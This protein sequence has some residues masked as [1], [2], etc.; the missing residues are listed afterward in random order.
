MKVS[1]IL[2]GYLIVAVLLLG[3]LF[4]NI[5]FAVAFSITYVTLFL[6]QKY[7]TYHE[8]PLESGLFYFLSV[9]FPA[10]IL[11]TLKKDP[12]TIII[13]IIPLFSFFVAAVSHVFKNKSIKLSSLFF[14]FTVTHYVALSLSLLLFAILS[15]HILPP[16]YTMLTFIATII[17]PCLFTYKFI[18]RLLYNLSLEIKNTAQAIFHALLLALIHTLLFILVLSVTYALAVTITMQSIE[19]PL[20]TLQEDVS[21][22]ERTFDAIEQIEKITG[23]L[24]VLDEIKQEV[25]AQP[26][27]REQRDLQ[28]QIIHVL[29]D[30]WIYDLQNIYYGSMRPALNL[31]ALQSTLPR[32][33]KT[34]VSREEVEHLYAK[35]LTSPVNL[36]F[37]GL[38]IVLNSNHLE[39][40]PQQASPLETV[41]LHTLNKSILLREFSLLNTDLQE[42]L[43]IAPIIRHLYENRNVAESSASKELRY[44]LLYAYLTDGSIQ[45]TT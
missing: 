42:D 38:D 11:F 37:I 5:P 7:L 41:L 28:Q 6:L 30:K 13:F 36:E 34:Q 4:D 44:A 1:T 39:S 15:T 33:G 25:E 45:Q 29:N 40:Q 16:Q 32:L 9:W 17:A 24:Q 43:R 3:W 2:S 35:K 22:K 31:K 23:S 18:L 14:D 20:L 12:F 26:P 19:A 21:I 8:H 27:L 10:F